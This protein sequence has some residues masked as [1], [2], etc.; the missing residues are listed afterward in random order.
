MTFLTGTQR[1][2]TAAAEHKIQVWDPSSGEPIC[3]L[4]GSTEDQITSFAVIGSGRQ[5][6][7]MLADGR[8]RIWEAV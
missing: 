6:A 4:Q 1:V 7:G 5:V 8:I 3:R 2:L